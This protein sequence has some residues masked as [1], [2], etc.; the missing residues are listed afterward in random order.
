MLSQTCVSLGRATLR[1]SISDSNTD[2]DIGLFIFGANILPPE[3]IALMS[4]TPQVIL[5]KPATLSLFLFLNFTL[6]LFI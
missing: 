6:I 5:W 1:L 4:H 2:P 3:N